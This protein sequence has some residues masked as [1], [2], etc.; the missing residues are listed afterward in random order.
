[1]LEGGGGGG[2]EGGCDLIRAKYL[3][4]RNVGTDVLEQTVQTQ[5]RLLKRSSLIRV[6]T[7]CHSGGI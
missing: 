1:M 2:G 6:Y 3:Q 5:L 7:V 4:I